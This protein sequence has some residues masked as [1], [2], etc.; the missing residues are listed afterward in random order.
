[1]IALRTLADSG[2]L[3]VTTIHQPSAEVMGLF[4]QVII[5]HDG[6]KVYDGKYSNLRKWFQKKGLTIPENTNPVEYIMNI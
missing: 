3:I 4:D 2:K 5:L 6:M 1:M